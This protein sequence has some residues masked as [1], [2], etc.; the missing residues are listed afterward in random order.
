M[1]QFPARHLLGASLAVIF[2]LSAE[3]RASAKDYNS[4]GKLGYALWRCASLG[5]LTENNKHNDVVKN[6][7]LK[8]HAQLSEFVSDLVA[9]KVKE[10]DIKDVP[11]GIKWWL[12]AGPSVEFRMG[13]MWAQF[14]KEA[15]DNT[16][17][18]IKDASF[19]EQKQLQK[20]K[21]ETEF[22]NGNCQLLE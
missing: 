22:Q 21:A 16:W 5:A 11:I 20:L 6:L 13:Y 12:T 1:G 3:A 15:Y 8:G 18:N 4:L 9:G 14:E 10:A 19:E 7:F 17:P 2:L